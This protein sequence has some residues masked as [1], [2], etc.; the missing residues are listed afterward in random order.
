MSSTF[1]IQILGSSSAV[2][3]RD[4]NQTAVIVDLG[5]ESILFDAG[6]GVQKQFILLNVKPHKITHVVISHLHPDHFIGLIGMLC[7]WG[8]LGRHQTLV[9]VSPEGL[10]EIIEV[11]LKHSNITLHYPLEWVHPANENDHLVLDTKHFELR[12]YLLQHRVPC[13]G[14]K[15]TEA[16]HERRLLPEMLEG[17]K[18]PYKA[19]S[20]MKNGEDFVDE[21]G[22]LHSYLEY[23]SEAPHTRSFVYFTD[24]SVLLEQAPNIE[25]CDVLYHD[26]TFM[27]DI[28][29]KA[30]D[31]GHS[32][33][34]QAA[35]LAKKAKVKKLLL[36]HFSSRYGNLQVLENEART[37][38]KESYLA[39]EGE[40]FE[41]NNKPL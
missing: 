3:T 21:E 39:T 5:K 7:S 27:H 19:Y 16:P 20:L 37:I 31:T 15:L 33:S 18:L 24:T 23:T 28:A 22:T 26:S 12:S 41:V 6:E 8:L 1:S 32:T 4:R 30:R 35:E 13:F 40:I 38:F 11:Q 10:R 36:G 29:E 17:S 34:I 9:I 14:Y 2:P 25:G